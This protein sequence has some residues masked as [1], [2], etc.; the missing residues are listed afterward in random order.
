MMKACEEYI[1]EVKIQLFE[2]QLIE[3]PS[4]CSKPLSVIRYRVNF[5]AKFNE[6]KE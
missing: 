6:R 3:K 1:F 5:K 4:T 2:Q